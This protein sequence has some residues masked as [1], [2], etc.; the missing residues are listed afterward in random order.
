MLLDLPNVAVHDLILI[1]RKVKELDQFFAV[2]EGAIAPFGPDPSD[3]LLG[4]PLLL[5]GVDNGL[6]RRVVQVEL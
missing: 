3:F 2:V 5:I 1:S 6:G 4:S